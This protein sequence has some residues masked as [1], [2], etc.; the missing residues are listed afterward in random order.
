MSEEDTP[1]CRWRPVTVLTPPADDVLQ[2][3]R[4]LALAAS[5]LAVLTFCIALEAVGRI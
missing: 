2:W 4:T 5:V 3:V 1:S